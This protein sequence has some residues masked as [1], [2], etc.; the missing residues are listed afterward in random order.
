V[1]MNGNS[2]RK[3]LNR[4]SG[5]SEININVL[6]LFWSPRSVLISL[7]CFINNVFHIIVCRDGFNHILN[8]NE[9]NSYK[10]S[11]SFDW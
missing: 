3:L 10:C 6:P 7:W 1:E 5:N 2:P 11:T 4:I 9:D 8:G